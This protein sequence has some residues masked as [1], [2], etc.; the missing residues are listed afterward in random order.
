MHESIH[1]GITPLTQKYILNSLGTLF[2][3]MHNV[4]VS[5]FALYTECATT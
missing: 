3:I 1:L 5:R 2:E 4:R